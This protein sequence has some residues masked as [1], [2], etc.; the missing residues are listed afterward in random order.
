MGTLFGKP[1]GVLA[2]SQRSTT[3]STRSVHLNNDQP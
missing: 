3:I 1:E 2:F